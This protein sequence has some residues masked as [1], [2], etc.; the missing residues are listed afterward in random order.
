MRALIADGLSQVSIWRFVEWSRYDEAM[1][2]D[3]PAS[4]A[5][6]RAFREVLLPHLIGEIATPRYRALPF[7]IVPIAAL[8]GRFHCGSDAG[9]PALPH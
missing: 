8:R 4:A 3:D 2:G 1:A 6:H 7:G 9:V 5:Y